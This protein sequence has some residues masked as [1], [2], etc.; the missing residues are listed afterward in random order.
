MLFRLCHACCSDRAMYAAQAH[1]CCRFQVEMSRGFSTSPGSSRPEA[2]Q[3][4]SLHAEPSSASVGT[5]FSHQTPTAQA[6][7]PFRTAAY[8]N[9]PQAAAASQGFSTLY[10]Q[11]QNAQRSDSQA[12]PSDADPQQEQM[13]SPRASTSAA[14]ADTPKTLHLK[15]MAAQAERLQ[16]VRP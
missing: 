12:G 13:A 10:G 1:S 4:S 14:Q 15:T 11:S 2:T 9:S 8:Q 3:Q 7:N 16:Q 5:S 6:R